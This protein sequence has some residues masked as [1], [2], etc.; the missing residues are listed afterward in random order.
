MFFQ[1]NYSHG[2]YESYQ[3]I[4]PHIVSNKEEKEMTHQRAQ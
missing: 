1:S 2:F 4:V 3:T